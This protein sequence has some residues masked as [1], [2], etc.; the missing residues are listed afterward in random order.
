[1]LSENSKKKYKTIFIACDHAGLEMKTH[2]IGRFPFLPWKDLGPN[3][4]D[5]VDYPD[6]AGKLCR[7]LEPQLASSIGILVCGSGQGMAIRANRSSLIRAALCWSE[8]V[9]KAARSHNDANVLCLAG[10]MTPFPTAEKIL[11]VFLETEFEGG[12]HTAR[13]KKLSC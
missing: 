9:A 3:S 7:E 11:N 13:V 6:Y 12:R 10:R 1:M 5:S 8:E 2:L 4:S